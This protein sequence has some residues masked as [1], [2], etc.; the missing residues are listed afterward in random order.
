MKVELQWQF[1]DVDIRGLMAERGEVASGDEDDE[2]LRDLCLGVPPCR[3]DLLTG[4]F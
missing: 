4:F 1:R 2:I 3:P